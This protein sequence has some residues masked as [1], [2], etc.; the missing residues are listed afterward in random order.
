MKDV[1]STSKE[2]GKALAYKLQSDIEAA[3]DFKKV[4]EECILN[5]KVEFTLGE[6]L[7]IAKWEFHEVIIDIIKRKRQAMGETMAS[8]THGTRVI[9]DEEVNDYAYGDVSRVGFVMEEDEVQAPSHF[10]RSHWARATTETLVKLGNLEEPLV[11]LI[12]HGS[13]INLMSKE[14]YDM[15]KWPIDTDHGWLIR[16]ANNS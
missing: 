14:L 13:E 1:P 15:G 9:R 8:N 11:A 12:D 5:G 6:V 2:N 3:T 10:S 7:G 16:A 4:L